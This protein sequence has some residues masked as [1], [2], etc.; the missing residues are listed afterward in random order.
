MQALTKIVLTNE[1]ENELHSDLP[2]F[3]KSAFAWDELI[4]YGS[5]EE[6]IANGENS[7]TV[8][9]DFFLKEKGT[10]YLYEGEY[11]DCIWKLEER[12]GKPVINIA[13]KRENESKPLFSFDK[14][15]EWKDIV[16][17]VTDR[18]RQEKI[19]NKLVK[20]CYKFSKY[21]TD[22]YRVYD[23]KEGRTVVRGSTERIKEGFGKFLNKQEVKMLIETEIV[24]ALAKADEQFEVDCENDDMEI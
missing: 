3:I 23:S 10:M 4:G 5:I 9:R 16:I 6:K 2:S 14:T 20:H 8:I 24:P 19:Y 12:D 7:V 22:D 13:V 1:W 21:H 11:T 17:A 18:I 15:F